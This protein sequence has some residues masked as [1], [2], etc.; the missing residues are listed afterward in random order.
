ML[1]LESTGPSSRASFT[2]LAYDEDGFGRVLFKVI[3][4][5]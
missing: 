4:Q 1:G 2:A 3:A 5:M